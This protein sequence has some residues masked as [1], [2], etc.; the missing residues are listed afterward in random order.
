MIRPLDS[1]YAS[2]NIQPVPDRILPWLIIFVLPLF[3]SH[4]LRNNNNSNNYISHNMIHC[5]ALP[6]LFKVVLDRK[7]HHPHLKMTVTSQVIL[8]PQLQP[9]RPQCLRLQIGRPHCKGPRPL[10]KWLQPRLLLA[11]DL[12]ECMDGTRNCSCRMSLYGPNH[13]VLLWRQISVKT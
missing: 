4:N 7:V 5:L 8:R 12:Q 1:M 3:Y 2:K 10:N 9:R 11:M 13:L 6:P